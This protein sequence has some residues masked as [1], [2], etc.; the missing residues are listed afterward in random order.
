MEQ[1]IQSLKELYEK[2]FYLWVQ[3]NLKLLRNREYDLVDWENLLEEIEDMGK[4]LF[5]SVRSHMSTIM[6]HLYKWENFRY[7]P[8]MGYDWIETITNARM[9]TF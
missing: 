3:E 1:E 9:S 7:V 8:E 4:S 2:D 5:K 6:E